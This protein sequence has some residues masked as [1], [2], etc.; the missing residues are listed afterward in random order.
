MKAIRKHR[1]TKPPKFF[2]AD[3]VRQLLDAAPVHL[4]AMILLGVNAGLGNTDVADIQFSHLDLES[5]WLNYPRPKTGIALRCPLW[6]QTIEAI[7]ASVM[8]RRPPKD[9]ADGDCVF[10]TR[11]GRI[12]GQLEGIH[13]VRLEPV[14]TPGAADR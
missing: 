5:G 7:K 11:Q 8:K 3:E 4:K 9:E 1:R 10:L 6:P 14:L 2:D 13:Q 12:V